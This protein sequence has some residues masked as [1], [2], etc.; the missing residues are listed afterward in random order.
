[1]PSSQLGMHISIGVLLTETNVD[2]RELIAMDG[3]FAIEIC[4]LRISIA[5]GWLALVWM[6]SFLWNDPDFR[7]EAQNNESDG[8]GGEDWRRYSA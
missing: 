4:L 8:C 1:V 2:Q 5:F 6:A 3:G 7:D